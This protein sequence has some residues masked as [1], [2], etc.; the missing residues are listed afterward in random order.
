MLLHAP[1][2]KALIVMNYD[3]SGNYVAPTSSTLPGY[4][5]V[6][7]GWANSTTSGVY[8]GNGWV[9]TATHALSGATTTES[10]NGESYDIVPQSRFSLRNPKLLTDAGLSSATDLML[11]RVDTLNR[12]SGTPEQRAVDLGLEIQPIEIGE[13]TVSTNTQLVVI[14]NG[15]IRNPGDALLHWDKPNIF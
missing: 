7:P 12:N 4:T 8:L 9:I 6:D 5:D 1:A 2:A 11:F 15:R 3:P 10:I 14:G 13:T